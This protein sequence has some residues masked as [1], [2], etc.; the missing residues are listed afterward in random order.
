[1]NEI[2]E[3]LHDAIQVVETHLANT[4]L[5]A[6]AMGLRSPVHVCPSF[7]K[8]GMLDVKTEI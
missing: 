4:K 1:M 8:H 3:A 2:C 7:R 5:S 6:P